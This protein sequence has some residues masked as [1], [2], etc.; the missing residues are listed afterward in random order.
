MWEWS[1]HVAEHAA[2]AAWTRRQEAYRPTICDP[3]PESTCAENGGY[4]ANGREDSSDG[5]GGAD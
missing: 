3:E 2:A 5:D 4:E 1:K